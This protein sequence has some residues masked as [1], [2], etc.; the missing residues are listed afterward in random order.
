MAAA[1][2]VPWEAAVRRPRSVPAAVAYAFS[3]LGATVQPVGADLTTL[4]LTDALLRPMPLVL[5]A[6]ASRGGAASSKLGCQSAVI[7]L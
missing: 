7:F 3:P 4:H 2:V 6:G 5:A 1:G